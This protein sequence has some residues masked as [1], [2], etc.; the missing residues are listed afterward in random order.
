[1]ALSLFIPGPGVGGHCIPI[2]PI[3]L[4]WKAKKD[5]D[6]PIKFIDL[7]DEINSK[8]PHYVINKVADSLEK[9]FKNK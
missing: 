7:A 1:M 3:Y 2:D 5:F 6:L 9:I 4:S 8:M